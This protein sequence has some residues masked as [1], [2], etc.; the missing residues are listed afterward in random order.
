MICKWVR[1][2]HCWKKNS[3]IDFHIH[4]Y[5]QVHTHFVEEF[6]TLPKNLQVQAKPQA[7]LLVGLGH[8]IFV[9]KTSQ[10]SQFWFGM[11]GTHANSYSNRIPVTFFIQHIFKK[12]SSPRQHGLSIQPKARGKYVGLLR[13]YRSAASTLCPSRL[14]TWTHRT[15]FLH[16]IIIQSRTYFVLC[17]SVLIPPLSMVLRPNACS[18]RFETQPAMAVSCYPDRWSGEEQLESSRLPVQFLG[19]RSSMHSWPPNRLRERTVDPGSE[20]GFEED[21]RP[22]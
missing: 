16:S 21:E 6:C 14:L 22:L 2:L 20:P 17:A 9:K 3:K 7:L 12:W 1:N 15:L 4:C 11:P 13:P 19:I 10:L 18:S 8:I 5:G